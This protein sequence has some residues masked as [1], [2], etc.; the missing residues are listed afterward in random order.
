MLREA[1]SMNQLKMTKP[2]L[3]QRLTQSFLLLTFILLTLLLS[4]CQGTSVVRP[5]KHFYINDYAN[6]LSDATV[7]NI[8]R[9][10]ERLF[11]DTDSYINGGTILIINTI[12]YTNE[13]DLDAFDEET[14]MNTWS[15]NYG[16]MGLIINLYFTNENDQLTLSYE[17][18]SVSPK[19][20]QYI[21]V[22][23]LRFIIDKTLYLSNW[24]E[25]VIDLPIM[26]MYYELLETVYMQVY[27]YISF[28]YDMSIY[29]LYLNS[30]Q[31]D[32]DIY[33]QQMTYF[34]YTLYQIGVDNE[35]IVISYFIFTILFV[36]LSFLMI[37]KDRNLT[38][39]KR[40]KIK[41]KDQ[42]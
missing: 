28:T 12:L 20:Q 11:R 21:A 1:L 35:I 15:V 14:L 7:I 27:D 9:E 18:F 13:T 5:T 23:Q 34:E 39:L 8:T 29:E 16:S 37:R 36:S 19:L 42:T 24:D 2:K 25:S 40:K 26:H 17:K 38:I 3:K 30:Y 6:V 4:A 41:E 31:G 10:G 22:E 32:E 33:R